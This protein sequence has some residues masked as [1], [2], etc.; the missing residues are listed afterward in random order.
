MARDPA[1]AYVCSR[2]G[3][4]WEVAV[5]DGAA[6]GVDTVRCPQCDSTEV[7]A[8]DPHAAPFPHQPNPELLH[9]QHLTPRPPLAPGA[10]VGMGPYMPLAKPS[11]PPAR[12]AQ[13]PT[14]RHQWRWWSGSV[15]TD[16]VA[17]DGIPATDSLP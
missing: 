8:F 1:G 4:S 14:G 5:S 15:W 12:W 6:S 13:D 17:D 2:C 16:H 9:L 11:S 3:T 7:T 10:M